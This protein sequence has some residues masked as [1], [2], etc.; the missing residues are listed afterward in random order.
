MGCR[1]MAI[2]PVLSFVGDV[3]AEDFALGFMRYG[4]ERSVQAYPDFLEEPWHNLLRRV[5]DRVPHLIPYSLELA[6]SPIEHHGKCYFALR[7]HERVSKILSVLAPTNPKTGR[8]RLDL[9]GQC[10]I[11]MTKAFP[12]LFDA[13]YVLGFGVNGL[14]YDELN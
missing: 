12:Q 11:R 14:Y 4:Q 13:A 6:F 10:G 3:L 9:K 1:V 5:Q 7:G 8:M 2:Q